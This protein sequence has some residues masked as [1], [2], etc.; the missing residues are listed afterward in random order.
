MTFTYYCQMVHWYSI[1]HLKLMLWP[2][3]T[4]EDCGL[5]PNTADRRQKHEASLGTSRARDPQPR[6]N[7]LI[8]ALSEHQRL[9]SQNTHGSSSRCP[10]KSTHTA[11][12]KA[13]PR[14]APVS[15]SERAEQK[16][17]VLK[18]SALTAV[19][20]AGFRHRANP[21]C[22]A[23]AAPAPNKSKHTPPEPRRDPV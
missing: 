3:S 13:R 7:P 21:E 15:P 22:G 1:F 20:S 23:V 10:K 5:T 17:S 9:I 4:S 11:E 16:P 14:V 8:T 19:S 12:D 6:R 18:R 2:L